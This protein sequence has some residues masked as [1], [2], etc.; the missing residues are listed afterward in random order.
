MNIRSEKWMKEQNRTFMKLADENNKAAN[1]L[2]TTFSP[3]PNEIVEREGSMIT[4]R[5]GA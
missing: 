5:S 3:N 1:K 4:A 2:S